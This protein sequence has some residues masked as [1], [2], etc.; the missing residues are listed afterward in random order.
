MV[1]QEIPV[2]PN[3]KI[4]VVQL[5][6]QYTVQYRQNKNNLRPTTETQMLLA[7]VWEE[8]LGVQQIGLQD[9]FFALGGHSL[10]IMPTLV[11]LKPYFPTLHI[12][13]FFK[14]RTIEKLAEKIEKDQQHRTIENSTNEQNSSETQGM[15]Q[16]KVIRKQSVP[17]QLTKQYPQCVLLTGVTGFL[18]AHIL[19]QLL[20]LPHTRCF[21]C[22]SVVS[23]K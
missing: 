5:T 1:V 20:T 22:S 21:I 10:K 15:Q 11:K 12:Q 19:E 14:Y 7:T 2:T 9:D 4:D 18:G 8:V 23:S 13:D 17:L 3:G 16:P 6:A